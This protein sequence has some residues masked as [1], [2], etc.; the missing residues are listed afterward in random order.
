VVALETRRNPHGTDSIRATLEIM[1]GPYAGMR[2]SAFVHGASEALLAAPG[3]RGRVFSFIVYL[4]R[5]DDGRAFPRINV[6]T[7][8]PAVQ[9]PAVL[10]PDSIP[11]AA[12]VSQAA[13][14]YSVG[15]SC[16]DQID[17]TRTLVDWHEHFIGMAECTAEA[18]QGRCVFGSTYTFNGALSEHIADNNRQAEVVGKEPRGSMAG[19]NGPVYA[20]LITFDIDRSDSAGSPDL[21]AARADAS[22]LV[23]ALMALGVP[24]SSTLV[25]FSGSKGFHVQIPSMLAGATPSR[26]LAAV[27]G[28]FCAAIAQSIGV[29][30][31]ENMYRSLQPLRAPNSL[32]EKTGLHKVRLTVEELTT[33][34]IVDLQVLA[35]AARPF[36]P[37]AL[38]CE[39]LSSLVGQ[40][41]RAERRV[42]EA[43]AA[44][45]A[46]HGLREDARI[47]RSTWDFLVN[48]AAEGT[49]ATELY[50]AAANL[51][52]F[53]SVESLARALLARPTELSSLAPHDAAR[54]ID[55]AVRNA[56]KPIEPRLDP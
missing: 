14:D 13:A 41:R 51:M 48:G 12:D 7:I 42:A 6:E 15:F 9:S 54:H 36:S 55:G 2:L 40:W 4:Q 43:E 46:R 18:M 16:L 31:D 47:F 19:F 49:R 5:L 26:K 39:P 21:A 56:F 37:P 44:T 53:G 50:K 45:A 30:I 52:D 8:R 34:S 3:A 17:A 10:L 22:R 20:P 29:V 1:A 23:A 25:F 11:T 24:E 27:A 35:R 28:E 38:S 32:N 33:L